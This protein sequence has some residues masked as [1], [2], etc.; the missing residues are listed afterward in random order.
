LVDEAT[1]V[2]AADAYIAMRA[3][4]HAAALNDEDKVVLAPGDL[5]EELEA[6][7]RLWKAVF[8]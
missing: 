4:S 3:R 2:A 7:R 6:V 1:A 5:E 8:G